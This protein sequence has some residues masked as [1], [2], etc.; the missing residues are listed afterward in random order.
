MRSKVLPVLAFF[1]VLGLTP[2][3]M[4]AQVTPPRGG[5]GQ[6]QRLELE[7]RLQRGFQQSIM[8][9]LGLDQST[10]QGVRSTIQSFQAERSS[11]NRDQAS[12]R[13]RF[14]DPDL[15]G[16]GEDEAR[17][18]LQEMVDLQ[19]RELELYKREQAELLAF[20]TPVQLVRFYKLR[21][22]MGQRV[23]QLRQGRGQGVGP[24]GQSRWPGGSSG[25]GG[26]PLR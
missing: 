8:A 6:R 7:N 13:Y 26:Q 12:L 4:G 21:E 9:D 24:G 2:L 22:S 11:L 17:A 14:R 1:V 18:I 10:M 19:Q 3:S 15:S 20:L 23:N 25:T 5:Q 16:L